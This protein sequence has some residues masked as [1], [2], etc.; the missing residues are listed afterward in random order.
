MNAVLYLHV[1][2]GFEAA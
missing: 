1:L 2:R